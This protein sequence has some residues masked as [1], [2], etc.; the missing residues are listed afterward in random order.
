MASNCELV[1]VV[2]FSGEYLWIVVKIGPTNFHENS[3]KFCKITPINELEVLIGS[4]F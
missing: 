2:I 4:F 1:D 3:I